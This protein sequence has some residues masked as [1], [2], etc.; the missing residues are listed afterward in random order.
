MRRVSCPHCGK[1]VVEKVPWADGKN[2][3]TKVFSGFLAHW[4]REL[5]WDSVARHFHTSWQTVCRSVQAVVEYGLKHRD[6]SNVTAIGVDE[7]AWQ[8]GHSYITLVYQI[9][10]GMR[11][12]LWI[13]KDRTKETIE[14]F[15]NE[16][17][18]K[19]DG[20]LSRIKVVCS[21]MW[22]AYLT[23]FHDKIPDALNVL[24]RFHIM[25]KFN[26]A[27]DEVRVEEEKRLRKEKKDPVLSKSKWCFLKR[28]E[29]LTEKQGTKLKELLKMNLSTVK[30]YI[31]REQFQKLWDYKMA[32]WA[33]KF[34]DQWCGMAVESKIGPMI[35]VANMVKNH[36]SL[37]KNYFVAKKTYN[38]GIVEGINRRVNLSIRKAFGYKSLNVAQIALFHELGNLPVP[39]FTHKFW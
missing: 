16:M 8:K 37:I 35:R 5:S 32:C 10:E 13:G 25:Q 34:I 20:F 9:D 22:K 3:I 24:D 30:A 33:E 6:L 31:L 4:A 23:V 12:L 27:I 39:K 36:K 15:F 26:L 1:I 14:G 18:C 19:S 28:E 11:R 21:D 7:I 29:N 17:S 2:Q 38:S